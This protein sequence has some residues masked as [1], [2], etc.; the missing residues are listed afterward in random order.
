VTVADEAG[1]LLAKGAIESS[2]GQQGSCTLLFKVDDVPGGAKFYKVQ[3]AR[4]SEV[5]YTEAEARAGIDLLVGTFE[6]SSTPTPTTP[7]GTTTPLPTVDSQTAALNQ[8]RATAEADRPDVARLLADRWVPQLSAKR[9]GIEADG[10]VWDYVKILQEHRQL[11][12][13]YPG[14]RLL[15]SGDW[16]TFDG[17]GFWV[18]VAGLTYTDAR[19]ALAWCTGQGFDRDHCIAKIVSATHPVDDSTAYNK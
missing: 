9:P 14:V 12:Q 11:R 19:P 13:R 1:K 4:Q 18:T 3:I 15:W 6:P 7:T 8:L 5:S 10:V 17:P 16:S 2:Y